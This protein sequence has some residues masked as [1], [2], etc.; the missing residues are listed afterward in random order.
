MAATAASASAIFFIISPYWVVQTRL[1]PV[2]SGESS[3][4]LSTIV[5]S[6]CSNS[7]GSNSPSSSAGRS[8]TSWYC[9][10]FA[11]QEVDAGAV[12][13][14]PRLGHRRNGERLTVDGD[15][16]APGRSE[17]VTISRL[18]PGGEPDQVADHVVGATRRRCVVRQHDVGDQLA[19]AV[20]ARSVRSP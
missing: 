7:V 1:Y 4:I 6:G 14:P 10:G 11:G 13:G 19:L 5:R 15:L 18:V 9:D 8:K 20:R 17:N 3:Q 16:T 2:T 12:A